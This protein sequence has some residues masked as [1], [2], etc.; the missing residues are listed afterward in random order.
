MLVA[1]LRVPFSAS[2]KLYL[3]LFSTL[4]KQFTQICVACC[5]NLFTCWLAGKIIFVEERDYAAVFYSIEGCA[6]LS[7]YG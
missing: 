7:G 2:Q 5:V 6:T 1:I 3:F 4:P